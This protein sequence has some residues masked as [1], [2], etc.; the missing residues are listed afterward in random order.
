VTNRELLITGTASQ[1][2]TRDRNHNGYLLRWNEDVIL[3]DPGEGTQR[4]LT[5]AGTSAHRVDRIC[6]THL[7]GDHCLGLPGILQSRALEA[8]DHAMRINFP[9]AS[10]AYVE[11]LCDA[12][13]GRHQPVRLEPVDDQLGAV[14][15]AG[16]PYRVLAR[17]LRHRVPTIGYRV[18]DP[19]ARH[20]LPDRL[21]AAGIS[22][23]DVGRLVAKG[24]LAHGGRRIPIEEMSEVR[25]GRSFA[26]VLDTALC[27]GAFELADGVDLLLCEA[28]YLETE[29]ELAHEHLHL[30]AREAATIA[31]DSG[32]GRLVLTHFSSRY[33]DLDGH[34]AEASAVFDNVHVARDLETVMFPRLNG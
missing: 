20:L 27:D 15:M 28:T 2:P 25:R 26:I 12:S 6:L 18:D 14:V 10:A 31:R 19:P 3:F 4:Q 23:P 8:G 22:G 5:R 1:A 24:W 30:T 21:T 9:A 17:P 34:V 33:D 11:R 16:P 7:H 32:V 29:A 13:I